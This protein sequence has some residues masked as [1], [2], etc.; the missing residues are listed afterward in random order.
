MNDFFLEI[1]NIIKQDFRKIFKRIFNY[2]KE[3]SDSFFA[4]LRKLKIEKDLCITDFPCKNCN[5]NCTGPCDKIEMDDN[6]LKELFLKYNACPDCGSENFIEGPSGGLCTN[7]KCDGCG[8]WF[9]FGLPLF[10]QRIRISEN[11]FCK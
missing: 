2:D 1:W 9:N 7:V 5:E 4:E 3:L 11:K 10:I 8:H 6:K